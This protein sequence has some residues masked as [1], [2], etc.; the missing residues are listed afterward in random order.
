MKD[1]RGVADP[2]HHAGYINIYY[3]M[4]GCGRGHEEANPAR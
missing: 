1:T 3:Y 4:A 2:L